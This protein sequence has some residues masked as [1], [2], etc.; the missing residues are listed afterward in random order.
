[1]STGTFSITILPTVKRAISPFKAPF[2][3]FQFEK[4]YLRAVEAETVK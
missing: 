1:M 4:P 2:E 3:I